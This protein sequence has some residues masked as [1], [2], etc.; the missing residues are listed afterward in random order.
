MRSFFKVST[1][2]LVGVVISWLTFGLSAELNTKSKNTLEE[3]GIIYRA[4]ELCKNSK[5]TEIAITQIIKEALAQNPKTSTLNLNITT[6]GSRVTL[7]GKAE[8][9]EQIQAAI[10][11]V[12]SIPGVKEVISTVVVDHDIKIANKEALL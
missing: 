5:S 12:L 6:V 10:Q 8:D 11:I 9:R 3:I 4:N 2:I 1:F 7:S